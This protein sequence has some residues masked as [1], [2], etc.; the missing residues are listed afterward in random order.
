M[1]TT[2]TV[3]KDDLTT[4]VVYSLMGNSSSDAQ[5]ID[6]SGN[7]SAPRKLT[8]S[9]QLKS[10]GSKGSDRHQVLVQHVYLDTLGVSQVISANFTLSVPRSAFVTD[11]VVLDAIAALV[12]YLGLAGVKAS[13]IDGIIP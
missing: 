9:H 6:A 4:N 12:N 2:F 5:Y 3:K 13:L 8:V 1:L 11:T 7:L 10:V